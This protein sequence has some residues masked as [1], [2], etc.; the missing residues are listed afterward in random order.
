MSLEVDIAA[1]F[2]IA[3][4]GNHHTLTFYSFLALYARACRLSR[5]PPPLSPPGPRS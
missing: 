5:L 4:A 1:D 3:D 2:A